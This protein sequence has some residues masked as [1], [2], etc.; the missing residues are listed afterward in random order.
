MERLIA[1]IDTSYFKTLYTF[2][3]QAD[4]DRA[5]TDDKHL[6]HYNISIFFSV[7]EL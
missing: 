7:K 3:A 4:L 2:E 5:L 1:E 6:S